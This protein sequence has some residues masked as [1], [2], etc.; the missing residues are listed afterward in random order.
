MP[1]R[2]MPLA[3]RSTSLPAR[4]WN[5]LTGY[6]T[7]PSR[8]G[9]LLQRYAPGLNA[10]DRRPPRKTP[11]LH[12]HRQ[13]VDDA[14]LQADFGDLRMVGQIVDALL[15]D[16]ELLGILG[17]RADGLVS[18]PV[19]ITGDA[20]AVDYWRGGN[21]LDQHA[22]FWQLVDPVEW[23]KIIRT[24]IL[25]GVAVGEM[26]RVGRFARRLVAHSVEFLRYDYDLDQWFFRG[27][28]GEELITP[29]DGRWVLHRPGGYLEPWKQGLFAALMRAWISKEHALIYRDAYNA[30]MAHPRPIGKSPAAATEGE[31]ED[32]LEGLLDWGPDAAAVLPPGWDVSLL[33]SNGTGNAVFRDTIADA[34]REYA[35][36]TLG[37]VGTTEGGGAF[38]NMEVFDRVR[39]DIIKRDGL[40]ASRTATEQIVIPCTLE[41]FGC[42]NIAA[43]W[44]TRKPEAL[45]SA[46]ASV[47]SFGR[48]LATANAALAGEG[49]SIDTEQYA[50]RFAVP[51]RA[52]ASAPVQLPALGSMTS[53]QGAA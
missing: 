50:S 14:L 7:R 34:N 52:G 15:R 41:I 30:K 46:A 42:D 26:V 11:V 48:S 28:R 24:G 2:A 23:S 9:E 20:Q 32:L 47:E 18:L 33:E 39:A 53:Q 38:S 35:V 13:M 6:W 21:V 5:K 12:W 36:C 25:A 19:Q 17:A 40:V 27:E 31:R 22:P 1:V 3:P 16:G 51:L 10:R 4:I 43:F 8:L 37:Q 29:G 49:K 45:S 44:D